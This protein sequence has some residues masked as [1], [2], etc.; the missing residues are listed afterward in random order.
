M[1]PS[2]HSKQDWVLAG[3]VCYQQ[4]SQLEEEVAGRRLHLR[5]VR[6]LL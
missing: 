1:D 3:D 5:C 4:A 2:T 6:R